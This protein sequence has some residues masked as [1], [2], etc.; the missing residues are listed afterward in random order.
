MVALPP[1]TSHTLLSKPNLC[2]LHGFWV[3]MFLILLSC[4]QNSEGYGQNSNPA[5]QPPTRTPLLLDNE[6]QRVTLKL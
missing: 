6:R 3:Q 5:T 1:S 2:P 4:D